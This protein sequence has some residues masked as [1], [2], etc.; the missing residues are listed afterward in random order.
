M[1]DIFYIG[2]KDAQ[3]CKLKEKF[4]T[5]KL[6]DSFD[7]AHLQAITKFFWCVWSDLLVKDDF[8][9]DYVPDTGSQGIS[10]VFLNDQYT[11]GIWLLPKNNV[12]SKREIEN[13]FL[14]QKKQVNIVASSPKL[15]DK[16]II[17]SYDEYLYALENS[18]TE[19]F[20]ADSKIIDTTGYNF[21]LYFPT[22]A[23]RYN[24]FSYS[25]SDSYNRFENHVFLHDIQGEQKYDGLFLL[26]KHKPLTKNEIEYRH[27]VSRKEWPI[28]ASTE[29]YYD[30]FTI[31]NYTD[32]IHALNNTKTEL[33]WGMSSDIITDNFE[34]NLYCNYRIDDTYERHTNHTF[35]N[36][37]NDEKKENGVFLFST[38]APV[39]E[40]EIAFRHVVNKISH[41]FV[42]SKHKPYDCVFISYNESFADE[43]FQKLL[44]KYPAAKRIHGVRGIHQAHIEA[45]KIC[46][47]DMFWIVDADA[48]IVDEFDFEYFVE[49]WDRDT[50]HVWRS[51]NPINNLVYGYG[52]V[53]LF[54]RQLTID[55]DLSKPDMTTS[56]TDKFKA[57]DTISNITAF[58][59]DP[60]NTWKSAFR[61]CCKL[62]AKVIDRQKNQETEDRLDVWCTVGGYKPFGEYA[63]LGAKAGREYGYKNKDNLEALKKIN[64]FDWLKEVYEKY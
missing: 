45:A 38:H 18:N 1:F 47:R 52:G 49:R 33:F 58:N 2:K 41:K 13:R 42:A 37:C 22:E 30:K 40:R 46:S 35:Q 48:V 20:W 12:I 8:D 54:P 56:I 6:V 19:L 53:K 34:F 57:M 39:S 62:A 10:H 31:D 36:M 5:I 24:G 16:F 27:I 23:N 59:T 55:M 63:I 11:D 7:D 17:D 26:S 3:F 50:V 9:F 21:D 4:F 61:E 32:Y 43:N 29:K 44:K 64:D 28:V 51:Q 15:Y 25:P 14:V 60:F